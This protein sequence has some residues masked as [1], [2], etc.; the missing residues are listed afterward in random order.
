ME[1]KV[2]DLNKRLKSDGII[3]LIFAGIFGFLACE[4]LIEFFVKNDGVFIKRSIQ[5]IVMAIPLLLIFFIIRR[6]GATGKPFDNKN[7]RD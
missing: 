6:T 5:D 4:Q 3:S 1:K 7:I 2:A